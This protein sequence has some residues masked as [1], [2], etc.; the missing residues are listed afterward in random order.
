MSFSTPTH[1]A[2]EMLPLMWRGFVLTQ[3]RYYFPCAGQN[4]LITIS[5]APCSINTEPQPAMD[6][7]SA[8]WLNPAGWRGSDVISITGRVCC[9]T[10]LCGVTVC[11]CWRQIAEGPGGVLGFVTN[12]FDFGPAADVLSF[13]HCCLKKGTGYGALCLCMDTAELC[14]MVLS[15]GFAFRATSLNQQWCCET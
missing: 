2:D 15:T 8:E 11:F 14:V 5:K 6:I 10:R 4:I 3:L 13:N 12:L 1:T 9:D 7:V